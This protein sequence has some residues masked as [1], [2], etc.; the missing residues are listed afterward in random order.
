MDSREIIYLVLLGCC[1]VLSAFFSGS[2]TAFF[3]L[4]R[5]RVEQMASSG[6]KGAARVSMLIR[7]PDRLLSIILLG[8]NLAST[9]IPSEVS[10]GARPI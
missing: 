3:S 5:V 8:N 7:R 4:Q 10:K 6:I 9:S 2:E 1:L